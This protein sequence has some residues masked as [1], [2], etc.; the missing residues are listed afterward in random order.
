[1]N[2]PFH[3]ANHAANLALVQNEGIPN[4]CTTG[5]FVLLPSVPIKNLQVATKTITMTLPDSERI[6]STHI[7]ILDLPQLSH[8][9][10]MAHVA[11]GQAHSFLISTQQFYD[12]DVK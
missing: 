9:L 8:H 11:L 10:T 3:G 7:C 5:Y 2:M 1:M 6:K 4:S 12:G